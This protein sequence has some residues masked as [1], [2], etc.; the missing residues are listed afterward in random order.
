MKIRSTFLCLQKMEF[1]VIYLNYSENKDDQTGDDSED[2]YFYPQPSKL[3]SREFFNLLLNCLKG[4]EDQRDV[5]LSSLH[6]QLQHF[7][8]SA[9]EVR[10]IDELFFFFFRIQS[11]IH[12]LHVR[13]YQ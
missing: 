13:V 2:E 7:V 8:R 12:M 5:L 3:A 10:T 9:Q 11:K 1:N 4:H 6:K